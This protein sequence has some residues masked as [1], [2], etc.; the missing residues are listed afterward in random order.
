MVACDGDMATRGREGRWF[1]KENQ[2][3]WFWIMK[4]QQYS[5]TKKIH[6]EFGTCFFWLARLVHYGTT[7]S[8]AV[9]ADMSMLPTINVYI[10]AGSSTVDIGI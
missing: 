1:P 7:H 5:K 3:D 8:F 4:C 6:L 2:S 10:T 9:T